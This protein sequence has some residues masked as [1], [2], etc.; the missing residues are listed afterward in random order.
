MA[1]QQHALFVLSHD[2]AHGTL[3]RSTTPSKRRLANEWTGR[4]LGWTTGFSML[5]YRVVHKAH[6]AHL[7]KEGDPDLPLIAGYPKSERNYLAKKLLRDLFGLSALKTYAYFFGAPMLKSML[8]HQ[9]EDTQKRCLQDRYALVA[10]QVGALG[11][12]VASGHALAYVALWMVPLASFL[13]PIL[14]LRAV[15]EHGACTSGELQARTNVALWKQ[16][17]S[18]FSNASAR[19]ALSLL[20]PHN[21]NYHAEHHMA[22]YVPHEALPVLHDKMVKSGKTAANTMDIRDSLALVF[23][24]RRRHQ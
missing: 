7:F 15:L 6:H 5:A 4:A 8:I 19:L 2:A 20:F 23:A 10:F 12:S 17:R 14:R 1:T 16:D 11:V 3:F 22:P 13:H 21:V 24:R 18:F 9:A